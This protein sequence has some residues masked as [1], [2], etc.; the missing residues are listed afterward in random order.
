MET[1]PATAGWPSST[2]PRSSQCL[3]ALP[4]SADGQQG[5]FALVR[6][7]AGRVDH[8]PAVLSIAALRR[9][10]LRPFQQLVAAAAAAGR[11]LHIVFIVAALVLLRVLP[12]AS[13]QPSGD[14]DPTQPNPRDARPDDRPAVLR[15]LGHRPAP[16]GLV[17]PFLP[18]P[19][20]LSA[21]R[22]VER[23]LAARAREL[24]IPLRATIRPAAPS[25]ALVRRL[26]RLRPAVR[27][28]GVAIASNLTLF[29]TLRA[30]RGV[31]APDFPAP[32]HRHAATLHA[33]PALAHPPRVRIRR[34]HGHDQP[35]LHRCR[36]RAV[37]VG[38]STRPVLAH[39]HH[40][41]RPATSGIDDTSSPRSPFVADLLAPRVLTRPATASAKLVRCGITGLCAQVDRRDVSRR[42][43]RRRKGNR[44]A[45]KSA[46][47][48]APR[49]SPISS[50]CSASASC[51]TAN[52]P[53][54]NRLRAISPPTI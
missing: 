44:S 47:G 2:R 32:A 1:V 39:V 43:D 5:D 22:T 11:V 21:L 20:A 25:H 18:R 52:W 16:A 37:A 38:R 50:P 40:R 26:H 35:R 7:H 4:N 46:S 6:R 15:P 29:R 42:D 36:R 53:G 3:P 51:A 31:P 45:R 30:S 34:P 41:V 54:S 23:R 48:S 28:R 17:R 24:P 13:W 33:L 49:S 27:L 8:V 9:L 19:H 14:G 12:T 10:R